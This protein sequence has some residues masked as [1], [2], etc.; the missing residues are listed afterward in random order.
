M[1][2]LNLFQCRPTENFDKNIG[3]RLLPVPYSVCGYWLELCF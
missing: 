1:K 2:G 3:Y